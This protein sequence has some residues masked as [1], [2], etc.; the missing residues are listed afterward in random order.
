MS[1][2]DASGVSSAAAEREVCQDRV[3]EGKRFVSR[4]FPFWTLGRVRYSDRPYQRLVGFVTDPTNQAGDKTKFA[5]F[6]SCTCVQDG[7]KFRAHFAQPASA[8]ISENIARN[9]DSGQ[10]AGRVVP[11][12]R[13]ERVACACT[14]VSFMPLPRYSSPQTPTPYVHVY[15]YVWVCACLPV[16]DVPCLRAVCYVWAVCVVCLCDAVTDSP[17]LRSLGLPSRL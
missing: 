4:R 16:R 15:V 14:C 9:S 1:H 6:V 5:I 7:P 10:V 13:S 12:T 8:Q 17:W 11:P 2:A 3:V